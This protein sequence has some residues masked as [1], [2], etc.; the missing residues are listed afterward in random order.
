MSLPPDLPWIPAAATGIGSMPGTSAKQAAAI[1]AG[2]LPDLVHLPE[3][4][5]RGPG[6]DLLGRT[7]SMIAA[8]TSDLGVET[9][10]D[11]WRIAG[12]IGRQMRRAASWLGE[13]LDALEE[14]AEGYAGPVKVQVAGPWTLC[15]GIE[16]PGGERVLRDP[17]ASWEIA[18]ALAEA[19]QMH[20]ADVRRRIPRASAILVQLDEPSIT[21]VLAGRVGTASGLSSY[22][23]VDAQTAR[24]SL[25]VVIEA[26][27]SNES[28]VGFHCCAPDAP[29]DLFRESGAA[30]VSID[31]TGLAQDRSLDDRLGRAFD[32]GIGV[33]LG[34]LPSVGV[35]PISDVAAARPVTSVL[36]RLGLASD[37]WLGNVVVTPSCGLAAANPPYVREVLAACRQVGRGL[38]DD[39]GGVHGSEG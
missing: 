38:R 10:P 29:V 35:G 12:H 6:S 21:A 18:Q 32:A 34:A 13:D 36:H 14:A 1:V 5:S 4:P 25:E 9:T 22:R 37:A 15:A 23:A 3:L 20:V 24:R 17:G 11:G 27:R 30:F 28:M 2:E 31:A 7:A 26:G 19:V 33:W 39:E 16:L 8:V